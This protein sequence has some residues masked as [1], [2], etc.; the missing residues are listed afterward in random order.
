MNVAEEKGWS[1][2]DISDMMNDSEPWSWC[3][4]NLDGNWAYKSFRI[5]YFEKPEDAMAF[6]LKFGG[7]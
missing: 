7:T 6:K 5:Y 2:V 1:R 4:K 3:A